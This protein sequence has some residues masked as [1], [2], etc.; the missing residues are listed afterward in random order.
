[1]KYLLSIMTSAIIF[2]GCSTTTTLV[3]LKERKPYEDDNVKIS[4]SAAEGEN[5][6]VSS[7]LLSVENKSNNDLE[8]DW[9]KTVYLM[10]GSSNGGFMFDGIVY[11]QRNA[12]KS[13]DVVLSKNRLD[14]IILPNNLVSFENNWHH[15]ELPEGE[16]GISLVYVMNGTEKR[17][18]ATIVIEKKIEKTEY[19]KQ[20]EDF[21]EKMKNSI[22]EIIGE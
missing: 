14:K 13:P 4:L 2:I 19:G 1:M 11:L 7:L 3:S 9:N 16:N 21:E 10:N 17:A 18:T 8:I 20:V 15:E 6:N 22:N 12:P 5:K